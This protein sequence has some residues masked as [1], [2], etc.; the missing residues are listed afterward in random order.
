[1]LWRKFD[2][3][4]LF[5]PLV[6]VNNFNKNCEIF[7]WKNYKTIFITHFSNSKDRRYEII[8]KAQYEHSSEVLKLLYKR[9]AKCTGRTK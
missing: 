2:F 8:D 3:L 4:L 1:M 7:D 6:V 9:S 5:I